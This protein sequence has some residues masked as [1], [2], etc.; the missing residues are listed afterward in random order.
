MDHFWQSVSGWFDGSDADFYKS[1]IDQSPSPAH[2]VEV[3]SWK[4]RSSAYMVVE[5]INSGKQIQIDCVDT[6]LGSDGLFEDE[7]VINN[8]LF[9]VFTENMK[10][11]EGLYKAV[12]LSSLEAAKLYEDNSLDLVFIDA[13]H[14]YDSVK[15]DITAWYP[16]VKN[17]GIISGHDYAHVP[18]K[19]AVC[20]LLQNIENLNNCWFTTKTI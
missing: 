15:A 9:E 3:G 20:E 1:M 6:W 5:S 7:D 18:V 10:P 2:F 4:G 8:R 19:T 11:V 14:D 17:G 12:R 16:K 13:S